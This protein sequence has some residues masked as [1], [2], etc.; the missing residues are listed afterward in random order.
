MT[1]E[2][3]IALAK[4]VDN[5]KVCVSTLNNGFVRHEYLGTLL[6]LVTH[7]LR[8]DNHIGYVYPLRAGGLLDVYRNEACELFLTTD[9]EWLLFIDSDQVIPENLVSELLAVASPTEYPVV[10]GLYPMALDEGSRP[11]IFVRTPDD[12]GR[13]QMKPME[14][15]DIPDE[16]SLITC[17]GTGA[18]ALL[19]HRSLLVAMFH[20]Y[21]SPAPWFA[22]ETFDGIRYGED[23]TFCMRVK[24]MGFDPAVW[25]GVDIGHVKNYILRRPTREELDAEALNDQ[26]VL[27]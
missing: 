20:V 12:Q 4:I 8:S 27:V 24:A 3:E 18:G 10:C 17:D 1:P 22:V 6:G 7:D 13:I 21:G 2:A 14:W 19:I 25:T 5:G 15:R 23:F 16:S 11:N 9:C 26:E